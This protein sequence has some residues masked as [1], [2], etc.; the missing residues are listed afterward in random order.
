MA[1]EGFEQLLERVKYLPP[2]E[3]RRLREHLDACLASPL[4]P[5]KTPNE[6]LLR[7]E[8]AA[9]VISRIP[10]PL[11]EEFIQQWRSFQPIKIEGEPLSETII[12]DR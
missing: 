5:S 8:M 6:E 1:T 9:G 12:R 11:T 4:P 7:R 2:E 10:P 3:Q